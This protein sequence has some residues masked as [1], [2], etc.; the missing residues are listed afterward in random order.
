MPVGADF[1]AYSPGNAINE[2]IHTVDSCDCIPK[3]TI[4]SIKEEQPSQTQVGRFGF[5]TEPDL[6]KPR[7]FKTLECV[8]TACL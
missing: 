1:A 3:R 2:N 8:A 6:H 4:S 7:A 5:L